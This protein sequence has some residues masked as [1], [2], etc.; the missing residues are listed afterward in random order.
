M[1]K[2]FTSKLISE[3]FFGFP[4]GIRHALALNITTAAA[5][6]AKEEEKK[7]FSNFSRISPFSSNQTKYCRCYP[8]KEARSG[9][10]FFVP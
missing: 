10:I 3:F 1:K 6:Q 9:D 2:I 7:S 4:H 5:P 8:G